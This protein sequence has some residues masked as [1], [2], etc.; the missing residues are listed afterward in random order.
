[1]A[2]LLSFTYKWKCLLD[3]HNLKILFIQKNMETKMSNGVT[4]HPI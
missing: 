4:C 1:M 3:G 2:S